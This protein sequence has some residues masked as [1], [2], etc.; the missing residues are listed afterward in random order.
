MIWWTESTRSFFLSMSVAALSASY[1]GK[2]LTLCIDHYLSNYH[3]EP[4]NA[5]FPDHMHSTLCKDDPMALIEID[6]AFSSQQ[7][8]C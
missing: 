8:Q 2:R 4:D 7:I 3:D 1:L 5:T 6:V